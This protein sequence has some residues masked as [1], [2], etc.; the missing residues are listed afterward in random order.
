MPR[1]P[2]TL[3]ERIFHHV[4]ACP[5]KIALVREK[6]VISYGE[7]GER[8]R[9]SASVLKAAGVHPGDRVILAA[10]NS[11]AFVY[12]Y[13]ATH[14][15]SAIAV[16]V[17]PQST[18]ATLEFLVR[19]VEP[20]AIFTAR[21]FDS[22]SLRVRGIEE[23]S[24][25]NGE[26]G[27]EALTPPGPSPRDAADILYTTGTTGK[28]KG[29]VLTHGNILS[30]AENINAFIGNH[31]SDRELLPLPLSHS[32][33]LGRLR[34]NLLAGGGLVLANGFLFVGEIFELM[35]QWRTTGFCFVPSGLA[36]LFQLSGDQIGEF[37]DQLKYIEI[38]SAPMP[39]DH[40]ERL[41]RLLPS[42]RICMHYGLTEASRSSFI[43]FNRSGDKLESAGTPSPNVEIQ[44][45]GDCGQSLP[46]GQTGRIHIRGPHVMQR[47]WNQP[48][49][50]R[51]TLMDG[52]LRTE[53]IGYLDEE[54]F[55]FLEGRETDLVNVGGRKVAP[56][57]VED[58]LNQH[59]DITDCACLG[60]PDPNGLS[61]ESVQAFLVS[62]QDPHC[63]PSKRDLTVFLRR[64][65]EPYKI[66]ADFVWVDAIPKTRS[67]KIQRRRL[68]ENF[69]GQK[70]P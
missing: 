15:L 3:L 41:L 32:F 18:D 23:L 61:G 62:D 56:K 4:T 22:P 50:T 70:K 67:G 7:L 57:Q 16:P 6:E 36:V 44:I 1:N 24:S 30:A 27:N 40:K 10:E 5:D 51:E 64:F 63:K 47:Y 21:K 58:A 65:L 13:L 53:D 34:C 38:G 11:P 37:A 20:K 68:A 29:V 2:V 25:A 52:W 12:G 19:E 69:R 54:G 45:V 49:L 55:L 59:P 14:A 66:P 8:I 17:D 33:G 60:V 48:E 26:G 43:D 39:R 28:P 42:T 35:K 9:V 31:A 46:P